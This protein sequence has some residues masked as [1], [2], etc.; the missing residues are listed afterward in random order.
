MILIDTNVLV[1][2]HD[3]ADIP[4]QDRAIAVLAALQPRTGVLAAQVLAEFMNAT[5]RA[6]RGMAPLLT[7][8]EAMAVAI[9]LVSAFPVLDLSAAVVLEAARGVATYRLPY[10][11]AQIWAVAKLGHVP[12]VLT[13]DFQ[14]GLVLEGVR[15]VDPFSPEFDASRWV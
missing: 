7:V 10:Y 14:N 12:V 6:K 13:E 1:Y 9:R 11:D 2:A 3:V 4:R 15:F 5:T 8:E